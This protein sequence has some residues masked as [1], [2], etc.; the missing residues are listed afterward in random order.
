MTKARRWVLETLH[1]ML[2]TEIRAL[3][4][5]LLSQP[6]RVDLLKIKREVAAVNVVQTRKR[7]NILEDLVNLKRQTEAEQGRTQA[8]MI[9]REAEGKHALVVHLAE[10]NAVLSDEIADITSGLSKLTQQVEEADQIARQI[11]EDFRGAKDTIEIGGLSQELGQMLFQQRQSLPDL[12]SFRRLAVNRKNKAAEIGV[13]RPSHRREQK[14]LRDPQ[15]YISAIIG[16]GTAEETPMLLLQ[17]EDLTMMRKRLLEQA[18]ESDDKYLHGLG[19]LE[20]IQQ[21]LLKE[22]EDYDAFFDQYLPWLRSTSRTQLQELGALPEQ[23]WRIISPSGWFE[24][25]NALACIRAARIGA[26]RPPLATST[27]DPSGP[28][29]ERQAW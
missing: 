11:D 8:E 9:R 1:Q 6:M 2:S 19:E 3:S 13:R 24:V 26:R 29:Y 15:A 22:I 14:R 10:Q 18:V 20:S 17:L 28:G 21:L 27:S 4:Q 5:E 16:A 12:S 23:V 7:V 25:G